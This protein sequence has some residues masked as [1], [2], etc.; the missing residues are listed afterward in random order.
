[1]ATKLPQFRQTTQGFSLVEMIIYLALLSSVTVFLVNGISALTKSYA[2]IR[3][4]KAVSASASGALQRI[5]Y[6]VRQASSINI[7][8]STFGSNPG[9]LSLVSTSASGA[10]TTVAFSV[11]NGI[12][13]VSRGGVDEGPLTLSGA[14]VTNFTLVLLQN[15]IS[16]AIRITLTVQSS[17]GV[18]TRTETFYTTA[19]TRNM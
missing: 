12:L 14:S 3:L 15:S 17:F 16:N 8:G 4:A 13:R 10:T 7:G 1:M 19:V 2:D 6:E 9:V 11:N 5:V 18:K